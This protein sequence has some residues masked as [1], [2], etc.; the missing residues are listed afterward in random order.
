MNE[1]FDSIQNILIGVGVGLATIAL[2]ILGLT[3]I[4]NGAR[5]KGVRESL[6]SVGAV[7]LGLAVIGLST[8]AVGGIWELVNQTGQ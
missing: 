2:I 7:V 1:L 8:I 5:G 3:M 6:S 4:F